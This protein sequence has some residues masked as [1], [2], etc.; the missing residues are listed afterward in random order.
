MICNAT[1]GYY[2]LFPWE[3][4]LKAIKIKVKI[5]KTNLFLLI[6]LGFI[7]L[8]A[9]KIKYEYNKKISK[10]IILKFENGT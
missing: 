2:I 3:H 7:F 4:R 6:V 1:L 5:F 9:R 10:L 8:N